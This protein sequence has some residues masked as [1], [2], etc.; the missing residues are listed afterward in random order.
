LTRKSKIFFFLHVHQFHSLSQGQDNFFMLRK[1]EQLI[2]KN[3]SKIE[4]FVK[5]RNIRQKLKIFFKKIKNFKNYLDPDSGNGVDVQTKKEIEFLGAST[6]KATS[7][8]YAVLQCIK[9]ATKNCSPIVLVLPRTP[10]TL[11]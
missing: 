1:C 2:K 6:N 10:R 3:R 7:V 9:N 5:N 11:L 4:K 8:N